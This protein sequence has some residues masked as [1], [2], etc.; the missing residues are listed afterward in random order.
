MNFELIVCEELHN[1]TS[2]LSAKFHGISNKSQF[3][4]IFRFKHIYV[5]RSKK[6]KIN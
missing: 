2:K 1:K 6:I 4:L 5:F 3:I